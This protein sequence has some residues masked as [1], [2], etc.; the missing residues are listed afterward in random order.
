MEYQTQ[1]QKELYCQVCLHTQGIY[2][3]ES[4]YHSVLIL[5]NKFCCS[6]NESKDL[7]KVAKDRAQ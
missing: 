1:N 2:N 5:Y 7:R 4:Y 3:S 6:H